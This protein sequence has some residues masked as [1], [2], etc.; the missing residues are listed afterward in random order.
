MS[1]GAELLARPCLLYIDEATSGLDAGTEARM[2]GL[3]RQLSDEGRSVICITHNVDNV[4]SSHLAVFLMRGRLVFFGPPKEAPAHFSVSR[5]SDIYDRLGEK[6]AEHWEEAFN[7]SDLYQEFVKK[8][9]KEKIAETE[10]SSNPDF[11]ATGEYCVFPNASG[12][13]P[14][15]VAKE[16]ERTFRPPLWHQFKILTRR[17]ADLILGDRRSLRLLLLQAPIVAVVVLLGFANKPYDE[18]VPVPAQ[19][20]SGGTLDSGSTRRDHQQ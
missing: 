3:F 13:A 2:M 6:S 4:A 20:G 9:L 15:P 1:L 16:P 10:P 18:M 12:V 17:Y 8:R 14:V 5:L 7:R 11:R 19:I